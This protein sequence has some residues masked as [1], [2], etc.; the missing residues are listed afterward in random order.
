MQS[1]LHHAV[2][3]GSVLCRMRWGEEGLD[4]EQ[5]LLRV[6]MA[7]RRQDTPYEGDPHTSYEKE[8]FTL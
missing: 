5:N 4:P 7:N 1:D 2:L 6:T 3:N 8:K